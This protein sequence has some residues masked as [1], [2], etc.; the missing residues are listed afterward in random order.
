[1]ELRPVSEAVPRILLTKLALLDKQSAHE[2]HLM[3]L[4]IHILMH[5]LFADTFNRRRNAILGHAS[6]SADID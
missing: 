3:S 1:M 4:T 2:K 6:L 5:G